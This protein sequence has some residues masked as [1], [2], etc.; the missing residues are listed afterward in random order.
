M[1]IHDRPKG[2]KWDDWIKLTFV[3]THKSV[4]CLV[5][6]NDDLLGAV[7]LN[8]IH[9]NS[10]LRNMLGLKSDMFATHRLEEFLIE[11]APSWAFFWYIYRYHP[12]HSRRAQVLFWMIGVA[13]TVTLGLLGLLIGVLL[14]FLL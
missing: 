2:I 1:N 4:I 9:I 7:N 11:K 12:D 14:K 6:G 5:K 8:H 13:V 3:D 10:H